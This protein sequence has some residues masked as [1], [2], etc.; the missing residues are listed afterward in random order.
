MEFL[1][2]LVFFI[3]FFGRECGILSSQC[4][5]THGN[6]PRYDNHL[7]FGSLWVGSYNFFYCIFG[8]LAC[9]RCDGLCLLRCCGGNPFTRIPVYILCVCG[10]VSVLRLSLS[11]TPLCLRVCACTMATWYRMYYVW[12]RSSL[13]PGGHHLNTPV[14]VD[15]FAFVFAFCAQIRTIYGHSLEPLRHKCQAENI[16]TAIYAIILSLS[17]ALSTESISGSSLARVSVS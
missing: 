6:R 14:A 1:S 7:F 5:H 3:L 17:V 12:L 16:S 4:E 10:C 2:F 9:Y 8:V 11:V 15:C 13:N